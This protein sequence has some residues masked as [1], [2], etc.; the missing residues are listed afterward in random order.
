MEVLPMYDAEKGKTIGL[1]EQLLEALTEIENTIDGWGAYLESRPQ[2]ELNDSGF[3]K[4][5]YCEISQYQI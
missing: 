5:I 2:E 1:L 4:Y 3:V